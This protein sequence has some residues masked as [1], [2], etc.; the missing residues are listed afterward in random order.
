[1]LLY[2]SG[3]SSRSLRSSDFTSSPWQKNSMWYEKHTDHLQDARNCF[4]R[5]YEHTRESI[6]MVNTWLK[7][8]VTKVWKK[9]SREVAERRQN[10]AHTCTWL[11]EH[12]ATLTGAWANCSLV[13]YCCIWV[14]PRVNYISG[15]LHK[16]NLNT[17]QSR[18]NWQEFQTMWN[19]HCKV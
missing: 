2:I 1:M 9:K 5:V 17:K 14:V 8:I 3:N 11:C 13:Q 15:P 10:H 7:A 12:P 4:H 19:I 6:E 16:G 18:K